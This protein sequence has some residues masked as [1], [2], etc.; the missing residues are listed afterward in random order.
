MSGRTYEM[1]FFATLREV[2]THSAGLSTGRTGEPSCF[3]GAW[4]KML[5]D[6]FFFSKIQLALRNGVQT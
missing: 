1:T 5:F 4:Q 3:H 6:T 2:E